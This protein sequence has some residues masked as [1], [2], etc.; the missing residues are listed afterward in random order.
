MMPDLV[1][2][3]RLGRLSGTGWAVG[4]AG[5]LVSI[6]ITLGLMIGDPATGKTLLGMAPILGL[7]PAS[8]GGDRASGPFS[9]IW[10]VVFVIPLFLFVPDAPKRMALLPAIR[11]GVGG[12]QDDGGAPR[13]PCQH[14]A[15]PARPDDLRRRAGGAVR[16]RRHL[17]RRHLRLDV[18]RAR[19]VRHPAS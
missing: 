13:P 4:Y 12:T 2:A 9:A 5:G 8:F 17:R 10:Y 18:D 19:P 6:V 16:L 7:D 1:D 14:G 3:D 11:A 15:L